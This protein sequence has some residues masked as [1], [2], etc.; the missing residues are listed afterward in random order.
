MRTIEKE[1]RKVSTKRKKKS[2]KLE[3]KYE[4]ISQNSH[5]GGTSFTVD[6]ETNRL[7]K[8][9]KLLYT[10]YYLHLGKR[11]DINVQY[12]YITDS[13]NNDIEERYKIVTTG[14]EKL[15]LSITIYYSTGRILIQGTNKKEWVNNEYEKLKKS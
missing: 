13:E 9:K 6:N 15:S 1:I 3:N 4:E 12:K 2:K 5:L 8:W 11:N 7:T 14:K 10:R